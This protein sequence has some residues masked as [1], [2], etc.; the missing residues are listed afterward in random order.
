MVVCSGAWLEV[1][2]QRFLLAANSML[3]SGHWRLLCVS[4]GIV[5]GRVGVFLSRIGIFVLLNFRW[6]GW[7][8]Y[9]ALCE[10]CFC[11]G[12]WRT[13]L[14]VTS[15]VRDSAMI[16]TVTQPPMNGCKGGIGGGGRVDERTLRMSGWV[17]RWL[18]RTVTVCGSGTPVRA[19]AGTSGWREG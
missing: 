6:Q 11:D 4:R 19:D 10:I 1:L 15:P 5:F 3:C 13:L 16:I 9:C 12:G 17:L 2:M 18:L 14:R 7:L 8:W